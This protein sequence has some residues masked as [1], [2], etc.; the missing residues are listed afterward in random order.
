MAYP[1][2]NSIPTSQVWTEQFTGL[3]RRP[4][5]YDGTFNAMGNMTGEPWPLIASRKKRGLVAE[6]ER[7]LGMLAME[8][9]A[10]I[11]GSTLYYD[12]AATP[13]NSL[14]TDAA[15]LPKRMAGMG[16]YI[17]VW[18]DKMYYNTA[19]PTDYGS[20]DRLFA[21]TGDVEFTLCTLDGVDYPAGDITVSDLP[22]ENPQDGDLWID[23]S[24]KPHTLNRYSDLYGD[25]VGEPSVYVKIAAAGIGAGL[26][27][28][29]G[30][31]ISGIA[32]NGADEA[33]KEQLEALNT[34]MIIQAVDNDFI[35]VAGIIDGN[36][37]QTA[38][39]VRADR[40]APDMNL[41]VENNN[42]LWGCK[43]G[44]VDGKTVNEIYASALG[45]F[46]N[47]EKFLGTSQDS[48]A[49]SVGTAGPFTGAAAHRDTLY[50][51]KAGF[52]H[53]ME[54]SVPEYYRI[55]TTACEGVAPGAENTLTVHGGLIYYLGMTGPKVFETL[56][57]D[58]GKPLGEGM[59]SGGAAGP[60]GGHW[61]LSARE[62]DGS[63]SLYDFDAERGRWHR[64]DGAH[65]L[66]FARLNGET[67]M[68]TADGLIWA[69]NGTAGTKEQEDV[70]WYAETAPMGYE[71]PEHKRLSRFLLR[72]ELGE[73]A[74]CAF[75]IQYDGEG[76]WEPKGHLE[77]AGKVKSYQ[78]PI[79][80]R[81]CESARLRLEGH[82]DFKLYGIAR[83]LGVE[84]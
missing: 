47:F 15:M 78:L 50:F 53:K 42:R 81:R 71:Y 4:R 40:K 46:K 30:V 35:V 39:T 66:A 74:E 63:W 77:G 64:Q 82:G 17:L 57:Q 6:L 32:Y 58:I 76:P 38:G 24:S 12:G 20:I 19:D 22:P 75:S 16:A 45:D 49:A 3:D 18:P 70:T 80:P 83:E 56:P 26:A 84:K 2:L 14:S 31:R 27:Q 67:Y 61:M 34:T 69:L 48:Y 28:Q 62:A 68:L 7:P 59:L 8:K 79:L 21:S 33:L 41:I 55:T 25:W 43:Y 36:Y 5:T 73:K 11:D 9:L 60:N 52:V 51:F 23:T 29:D 10:W 37:T 65:A 13:V 1:L 72:M 44:A 54:G